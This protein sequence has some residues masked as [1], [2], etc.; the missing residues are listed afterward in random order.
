MVTGR[1]GVFACE[2]QE[3]SAQGPA[4]TSA[5]ELFKIGSYMTVNVHCSKV[6]GI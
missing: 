6:V 2:F 3:H 1:A 4:L 5:C